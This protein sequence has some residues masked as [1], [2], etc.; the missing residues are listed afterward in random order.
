MVTQVKEEVH[1]RTFVVSAEIAEQNAGASLFS[2]CRMNAASWLYLHADLY[3]HNGVAMRSLTDSEKRSGKAGVGGDEDHHNNSDKMHDDAGIVTVIPAAEDDYR[4]IFGDIERA[5]GA[6]RNMKGHSHNDSGMV[7]PLFR[8]STWI[9]PQFIN[10]WRL[11]AMVMARGNN[12]ES[13][14]RAI[15]YLKE[16]LRQNPKAIEIMSQIGSTYVA[17]KGDIKNGLPYLERA[18]ALA[19]QQQLETTTQGEAEAACETYRW[20]ALVYQHEKRTQDQIS[21]A[22]EGLEKFRDDKVLVRLAR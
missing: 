12:N 21:A 18:R 14:D 5:T 8:L 10:G 15:A 19:R 11:G 20:L 17:R 3:L 22:K 4:G 6:Y 7:L 1:P 9:D 2:Q 16:G 13:V